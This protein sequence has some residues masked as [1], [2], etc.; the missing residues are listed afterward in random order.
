MSKRIPILASVLVL[1]VTACSKA[2][3]TQGSASGAVPASSPAAV[4]SPSATA[5][6]I[7]STSA[8]P[9]TYASNGVTFDYPADLV[10]VTSQVSFNAQTQASNQAWSVDLG[11]ADLINVV[12]ITA[13]DNTGITPANLAAHTTDITNTITGLFGSGTVNG[14]IDT[15]LGGLTG[16]EFDGSGTTTDGTPFASVII[17]VFSDSLEYF[18]NCQ[19]TAAQSAEIAAGCDEIRSTFAIS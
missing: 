4:S 8:A 3:S 12:D 15:T 5:T 19:S 14:P 17:V 16:F 13:Y 7:A 1:A 9:Q 2:S 10:D 18:M 6:P 11:F